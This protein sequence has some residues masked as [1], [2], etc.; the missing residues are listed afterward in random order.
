MPAPYTQ[1]ICR[2]YPGLFIILLDQSASMEE[3]V[4]GMNCNKA[5]FATSTLNAL[6]HEMIQSTGYLGT[7]K[8]KKSVYLSILGYNHQVHSLCTPPPDSARV[9]TLI[10]HP[11]RPT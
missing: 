5:E 2:Q 4:M 11:I 7:G 1:T 6:I 3:K 8:L 9:A 10:H